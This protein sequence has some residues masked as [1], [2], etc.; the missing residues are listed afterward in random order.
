MTE[1]SDKLIKAEMETI[2]RS[3]VRICVFAE[4]PTRSCNECPIERMA[5][6]LSEA[7]SIRGWRRL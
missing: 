6:L 2:D 4:C 5:N 1:T 7:R 3:L